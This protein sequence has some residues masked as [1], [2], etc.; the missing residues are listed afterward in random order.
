MTDLLEEA[1]ARVRELPV[2]DQ[3]VAAEALLAFA[4]QND[5]QPGLTSE[6]AD[7]VRRI[8]A[9]LRDGS[10]AMATDD[11]VAEMWRSFSS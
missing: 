7:D 11:E 1:I 9:G 2:A 3:E 8:Q 4:D 5:V 6:Q 10:I